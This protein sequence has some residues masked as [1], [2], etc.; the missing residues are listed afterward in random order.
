MKLQ[1]KEIALREKDQPAFTRP[2]YMYAKLQV[3]DVL[4]YSV[5]EMLTGVDFEAPLTLKLLEK[6]NSDQSVLK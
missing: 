3:P 4:D 1:L 6:L 2:T 5:V